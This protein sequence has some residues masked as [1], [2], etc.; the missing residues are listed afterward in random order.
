MSP[1][2]LPINHAMVASVSFPEFSFLMMDWI[3]EATNW[4]L[5]KPSLFPSSTFMLYFPLLRIYSS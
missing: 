4:S 5:Y 3:L 2:C 1:P